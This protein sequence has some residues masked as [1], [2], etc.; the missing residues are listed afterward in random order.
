MVGIQQH[1]TLFCFDTAMPNL[2]V[3]QM[4][5]RRALGLAPGSGVLS[6]FCCEVKPKS[7]SLPFPGL[8]PLWSEGWTQ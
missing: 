5:V 2:W 6:Q 8:C 7:A 4:R 1:S 3:L